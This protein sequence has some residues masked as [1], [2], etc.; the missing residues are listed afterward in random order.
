MA[1]IPETKTTNKFLFDT[2]RD[3]K[4]LSTKTGEKVWRAVA[5]KLAATASQRPQVNLSK[6]DKYAKEGE[7]IIIPG[8]VLGDGI[9][10][11]KITIVGFKASASAVEKIEKSGSTFIEIK[12]Y[13]SKKP[14]NNVRIFG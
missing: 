13:I 5:T 7:T 11:K 14:N 10:S 6:I 3:L 8:K 1:V 9:L 2:I 4:K 12:N